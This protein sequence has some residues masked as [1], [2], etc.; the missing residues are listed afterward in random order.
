MKRVEIT[1]RDVE[2]KVLRVQKGW[3]A[4]IDGVPVAVC[5]A[6]GV[7]QWHVYEP[8]KGREVCGTWGETREAVLA[9]AAY[10]VGQAAE[11]HDTSP[12]DFLRGLIEGAV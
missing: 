11:M 12:G 8:T 4:E 2:G 1:Q 3:A 9:D 5:R 10:R 6:E 7:K